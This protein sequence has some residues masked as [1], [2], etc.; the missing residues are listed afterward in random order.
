MFPDLSYILH[1]V[2]GTE[3]DNFFS[4]VK[5]FGLMLAIAFV[6]AAWL[7]RLELLRKEKEGLMEPVEEEISDQK[8][9]TSSYIFNAFLGFVIGYKLLYWLGNTVE[10]RANFQDFLISGTGSP[11]GGMIGAIV[12]FGLIK[13]L[14]RH[15]K[16]EIT[17]KKVMVYPHERVADITF[18]AAVSGVAGAKLF[19][20]FES[21]ET[22]ASF[23]QNPVDTI[24][25]GS[26]LAIYG[27]LIVAFIVLYRYFRKKNIKPI[28]A[29]DAVAPSL[30]IAY[31]IGRMG[32][33]LSGDGDWGIENLNPKPGFLSWLPDHFWAFTYPHN[34][35]NQGVPIENCD[36][37]YCMELAVP[38]YPTPIYEIMMAFIIGGF[39]W[40][41]RKKIKI[42]GMLFF[43]YVFFNGLERFFIEKIRVNDKIIVFGMELTQ[44]EIIS[45]IL[46][47]IGTGG[48][49]YLL[50]KG[51]R[52]TAQ[53]QEMKNE[54]EKS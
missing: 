45:S 10:V 14:A 48:V 16:K 9:T 32:C 6:A 37:N 41:I 31:G 27:G 8:Y 35:L 13:F 46:M 36:W 26:G 50:K 25:S 2:L 20:I 29:M 44:A 1:Y 33:H 39:L 28:H 49:I 3:P 51:K 18:L 43:I 12:G 52:A 54:S 19:A 30:I 17:V 42:P 22:L 23:I 40:G 34:V 53:I 15:E 5:S 11:L 4:I 38:V 21:A 47:L 24:F 7:F